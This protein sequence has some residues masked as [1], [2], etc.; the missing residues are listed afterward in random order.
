MEGEVSENV[1]RKA[2]NVEY[3]LVL[4]EPCIAPASLLG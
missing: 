2:E 4:L 3:T 1:A